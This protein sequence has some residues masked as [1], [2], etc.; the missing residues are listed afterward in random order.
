MANQERYT[1]YDL[2]TICNLFTGCFKDYETKQKKEFV[3]HNSRNDFEKLYT[4]LCALRSHKY[5]LVGFNNIDFDSQIIH[6]IMINYEYLKKLDGDKLARTLYAK[7]QQ[8]L[9]T[10]EEERYKQNVPESQLSHLQLDVYKQKHYDGKA[11][12]T[13]LKWLE[14]T[15]R[16]PNIE[17]MP[18]PH[19]KLVSA[20]QI[21]DI[22]SY[23]WNDVEATLEFFVRNK[24]ETDLRLQLSD[25]FNINLLNAS[26]PRMAREILAKL[27]AQDAGIEVRDLKARRTFRKE[28]HL[29]KVIIPIVKFEDKTFKDLYAFFKKTTV[30][31]NET[32]ECFNYSVKYKGINIDYGVGGVHGTCG[33]G[34]YTSDDEFVIKTVD[35][36]SFYPNMIINYGFTPAHLGATF[37]NRYKWFYLE[38]SKY[39]KKDPINY[40]YKIILNSTYGLSND[41]NSFLY[42]TLVTMK[43]TINGQLLLSMLA[44]SLSGIPESQLIMMNTDGLEIRLPRKYEQEFI[45]RCKL[46][47]ELTK[48]ELEHDE[49]EKIILADVNNYIGIFSKRKAKSK[50]EWLS[51]QKSEPYYVYEAGENGDLYY[52]PTKLKGRFEIKMDWHKN[53]SGIIITKAVFNELVLGIPVSQTIESC[54]NLLDFCYGVKKKWD[55]DLVIHR[56]VN[57]EHLREV[58]QKVTRYYMAKGGGR[59]VK[60]YKDGRITAVSATALVTSVN[61]I[62]DNSIPNNLDKHFYIAEANKEIEGIRPKSNQLHLF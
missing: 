27:L 47:E 57:G 38:R 59:F 54:D 44:E 8:V 9:Q 1:V 17:E 62:D 56:V 33:S 22:L 46:W 18:L 61:R 50:E 19:D 25:Q 26:E 12:K 2:E 13:S 6:F 52:F 20:D 29:G 41:M 49:Y 28:I 58:Q 55:F 23:N 36:K 24:Y 5:Y 4:F 39:G 11:K 43:T 30:N 45:N 34:I 60:E 48:L 16:L 51:L 53:P 15:M 42:D 31:A 40:I 7:A 10:K 35:V 21:Q 37:S 32:R 3:I 14:F